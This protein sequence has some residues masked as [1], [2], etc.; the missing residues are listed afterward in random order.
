MGL[1]L[2]QNGSGRPQGGPGSPLG[3]I[4][5]AT[6]GPRCDFAVCE[7]RRISSVKP[8]ILRLWGGQGVPKRCT[9]GPKGAL[10]SL[11]R[12][13]GVPWGVLGAL[14]EGLGRPWGGHREG[15]GGSGGN[16][17]PEG[18]LGEFGK[19][20]RGH[21]KGAQR[22]HQGVP[23]DVHGGPN[24]EHPHGCMKIGCSWRCAPSRNTLEG[25]PWGSLLRMLRMQATAT[26][27][28]NHCCGSRGKQYFF[29]QKLT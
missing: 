10:G 18:V 28:E 7:K 5:G 9:R 15:Q 21:A 25:V 23:G 19:L 3:G 22:A 26:F 2:S 11:R 24:Q 20:P 4:W 27:W 17:G 1:H 12:P 6:W 8:H 13:M 16:L 14:G 29:L